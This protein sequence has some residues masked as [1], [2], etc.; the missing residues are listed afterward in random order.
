VIIVLNV[1]A[2]KE[3]KID[4]VKGSL[5]E[6]RKRV[7]DEFPKHHN[8]ILLG[9]FNIK[10]GRKYILNPQFAMKVYTKLIVIIVKVRGTMLT[11]RNIH[12]YIWTSPDEKPH[13]Q[14]YHSMDIAGYVSVCV[15]H[16]CVGFHC[17]TTCFGLHGHLRLCRIFYFHIFEGFY[18]QTET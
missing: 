12:K 17:F 2:P 9:D 4:D 15:Q 10:V 5:Y 7:F 14:I 6:E 8:K 18:T 1:R 16:Y 11:H 13:N 3:D